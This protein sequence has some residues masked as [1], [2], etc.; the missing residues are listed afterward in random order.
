M[1]QYP[2]RYSITEPRPSPRSDPHGDADPVL[3]G[4]KNQKKFFRLSEPQDEFFPIIK[5]NPQFIIKG[6][7]SNTTLIQKIY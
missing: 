5:V 3:G 6:F 2:V 1:L 4:K 7:S